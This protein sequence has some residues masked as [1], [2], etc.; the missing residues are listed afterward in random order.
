MERETYEIDGVDTAAC[1][2]TVLVAPQDGC[3]LYA[4]PNCRGF[5]TSWLLKPI[6]ELYIC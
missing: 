1:L 5:L 3:P 6:K 2:Y 4:D